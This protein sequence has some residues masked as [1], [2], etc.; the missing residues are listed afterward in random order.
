MLRL[1]GVQYYPTFVELYTEQIGR[2]TGQPQ[3][4][5]VA[6]LNKVLFLFHLTKLIRSLSI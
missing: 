1:I 3:K 2:A 4:G 5:N 6:I